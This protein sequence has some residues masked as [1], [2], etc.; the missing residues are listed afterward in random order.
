[1]RTLLVNVLRWAVLV[2]QG[3]SYGSGKTVPANIVVINIK[4]RGVRVE[5]VFTLSGA[6]LTSADT[7]QEKFCKLLASVSS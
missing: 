2:A 6:L 1:M 7:V 5:V 3:V 4:P